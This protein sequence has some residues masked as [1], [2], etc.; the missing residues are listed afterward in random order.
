M[1]N[2][3]ML[4]RI[5]GV[6]NAVEGELRPGNVTVWADEVRAAAKA[7]N[8]EIHAVQ[9]EGAALLPGLKAA[10]EIA[11]RYLPTNDAVRFLRNDIKDAIMGAERCKPQKSENT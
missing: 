4:R 11:E 8:D 3:E 10:L 1:I 2:Q 9:P 6:L 7:V 5:A